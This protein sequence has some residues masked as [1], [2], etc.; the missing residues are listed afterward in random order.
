MGLPGGTSPSGKKKKRYLFLILNLKYC[1]TY[2][3]K[4]SLLYRAAFW[5]LKLVIHQQ[6][7]YLLHFNFT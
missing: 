4:F 1:K 5:N 7:H 6:M 3:K 2:E